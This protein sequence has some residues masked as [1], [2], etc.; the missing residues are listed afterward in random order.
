MEKNL[1]RTNE[2]TPFYKRKLFYLI[3]SIITIILLITIIVISTRKPI[4]NNSYISSFNPHLCLDKNMKPTK[5]CIGG[6]FYETTQYSPEYNAKFAKKKNWNYVFLSANIRRD[7]MTQIIQEFIKLKISVHFMTLQDTNYLDNPES[8]YDKIKEIIIFVKNNNLDIQGI[9][10][11]VEPHAHPD[12]KNGDSE[13]RT[14]IFQNYTKILEICRKAINDYNPN[15]V[16]SAA[17]AW[18]YPSKTK[19]NEIIGGRG[20]DLVNEKRLDFVVPMIYSGAGGSL[21][22]IM[23]H[24]EEYLEDKA[25]TFIGI[26]VRDYNEGLEDMINKVYANRKNSTYF[27]GIS[28]FSN[29]Y[30][31]DWGKELN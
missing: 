1:I 22:S 9:H 27:Y 26:D 3:I 11:D 25:N 21:E 15:L 5:N 14:K 20:Y 2:N 17:V 30:Y 8:V 18:F 31:S 10:I 4:K 29:N 28:I 16:F 13:K 23:K 6:W 24:S 7:N 19:K 12:W